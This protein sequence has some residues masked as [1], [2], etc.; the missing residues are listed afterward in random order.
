MRMPLTRVLVLPCL[1]VCLGLRSPACFAH[2][3][4]ATV[5]VSDERFEV[6]GTLLDPHADEPV[7]CVIIVGGTMSQDRDGRLFREGVAPRDAL[8]R[9]AEALLAGGY[10]SYRYDPV[11]SGASRA[12]LPWKSTY[13]QQAAVVARLLEHFRTDQRFSHV[14]LAGES[15]AAYVV[16]L[17]AARGAQADGNIFL[18]AFCGAPEELYE[19]NFGRLVAFSEQSAENERWAKEQARMDLALGRTYRQMFAAAREE[20]ETFIVEDGEF[21][22]TLDLARRREEL[23]WPAPEQ[24]RHLRSPTLLLAGQHDRN[25]PPDHAARAAEI[26]RTAGNKDVTNEIIAGVDHSF[27]RTPADEREQITNRYSMNCLRQ[28]YSSAAYWSLLH[29]LDKRW[30]SIVETKAEQV[31]RAASR[32]PQVPAEARAL[33]ATEIA[34]LTESTPRRVFL[35]R[36]IEIIDD[37]ANARE[38]AGVETL[39]GRIGPLILGEG[40]QAHFID[41]PGGLYVEEHPHSSESI[42][43]TVRGE[44]VLCSNGRRHLMKPGTLFRFAANIPTGYEVPFPGNAMILIFKGDRVTKVESDFIQYLQGMAARLERE[45]QRGVPFLLRELREDHPARQFARQVNPDFEKQLVLPHVP[46][47]R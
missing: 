10:A 15:A 25:V 38:T 42:I 45:H 12:K 34:P 27:Q 13:E 7:P 24:F 4:E 23:R 37:I 46:K 20:K 41:M 9:L 19:Y 36:G 32:P 35:A 18:G 30:P 6:A 11:G 39:E 17:A 43:Y 40:S 31:E 44:W 5:R 33:N 29:W 22:M 26:L 21:R 14:I 2:P 16:C 47:E 8:K 3:Q 28:P 1:A